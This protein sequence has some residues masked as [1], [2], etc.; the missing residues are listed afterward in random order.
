LDSAENCI[1]DLDLIHDNSSK[2]IVY[3]DKGTF[4]DFVT[5]MSAFGGALGG[6][7]DSE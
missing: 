6:I 5:G 2:A 7:M 4:M 1:K 3:F